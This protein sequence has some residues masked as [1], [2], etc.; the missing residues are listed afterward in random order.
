[1]SYH[2]DEKLKEAEKEF[3]E[4]ERGRADMPHNPDDDIEVEQNP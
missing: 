4:E 1:M 2:S 3:N